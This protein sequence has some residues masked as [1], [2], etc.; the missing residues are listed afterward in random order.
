[1]VTK[2]KKIAK[3]PNSGKKPPQYVIVKRD[4]NDPDG[5]IRRTISANLINERNKKG[6][7]QTE[8]G[9]LIGV[10]KTTYAT[11]EQSKSMPS[12][13]TLYTLAKLY[14]VSMDDIFGINKSGG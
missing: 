9:K 7:T 12:V 13:E 8:V 2:K 10:K 5:I 6:L 3:L 14:G 4:R 1:M 11:W